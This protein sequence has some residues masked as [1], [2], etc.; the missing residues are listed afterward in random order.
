VGFFDGV[1]LGHR[2]VLE[3]AIACA[4]RLN[5]L[6][7]VVTFNSHPLQLLRPQQAPGLLTSTRHKIQMLRELGADACLAMD[8]TPALAE[9]TPSDFVSQL[10]NGIS[11]LHGISVGQNWRF[12]KGRAG[13]AELLAEVANGLNVQTSIA[14]PMLWRKAPVSSTRIRGCV[15]SG[16]LEDAAAMLGRTFSILGTVEQGRGTGRKLGYPTANVAVEGEVL[17]PNGVY[18]A[19][20]EIDGTRHDGVVN[21]GIHPTYEGSKSGASAPPW[22]ELHLPGLNAD[23]YGRDVEVS[24]A[25]RLREERKFNSD[26]ALKR[27]ISLDVAQALSMLRNDSSE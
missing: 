3:S 23:L 11:G 17:P 16:E 18:A 9:T 14:E 24:F 5:G 4:Q 10:K 2:K 19:H 7:W 8:F 25:F 26:L 1:H 12:G 22:V 13:N 27:Q 21:V 6:A 15:S 20:A